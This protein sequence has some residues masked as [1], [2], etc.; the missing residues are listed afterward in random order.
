MRLRIV[1]P[2]SVVVDDDNV[3]S[4]RAEDATGGF[5]IMAHHADFLTVVRGLHFAGERNGCTF[6]DGE[7][8]HVGTQTDHRSGK[9]AF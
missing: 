5:G 9:A 6:D 8:I 4:V 3:V 7:C 2:L 1:T